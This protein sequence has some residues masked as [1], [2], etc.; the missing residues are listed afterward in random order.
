MTNAGIKKLFHS[1]VLRG[2]TLPAA[3]KNEEDAAEMVEEW[4]G[5]FA[6]YDDA[7]V[8]HILRKFSLSRDASFRGWPTPS[9]LLDTVRP[10]FIDDSVA[11][12]DLVLAAA[13]SC[14]GD[15]ERFPTE[16]ARIAARRGM[17]VDPALVVRC[18]DQAVTLHAVYQ[19]FDDH[20]RQRVGKAFGF[21]WLAMK[22]AAS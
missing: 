16:V 8:P 14:G 5:I 17:G 4:R 6:E 10:P 2:Y 9:V 11:V 19:T 12:W 1:L 22:R 15:R 7:I 3:I 13:N 21:A 18:V 20:D